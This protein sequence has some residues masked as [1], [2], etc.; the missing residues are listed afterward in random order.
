MHGAV[1]E[2]WFV[3]FLSGMA[4]ESNKDLLK[5]TDNASITLWVTNYCQKNPLKSLSQAA[6]ELADEL[7]KK[8]GIR[9]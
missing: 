1:N 6:D 5:G 4:F 3:G 2:A 8:R 7:A 9:R